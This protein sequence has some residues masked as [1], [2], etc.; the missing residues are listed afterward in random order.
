MRGRPRRIVWAGIPCD[1]QCSSE[2]I[3][4]DPGLRRG[5]G[6][7]ECG[8]FLLTPCPPHAVRTERSRSA[9]PTL[10]PGESRG[11]RLRSGLTEV[12]R[13]SHLRHAGSADTPA[14]SRALP[15]TPPPFTLSEVE[16]YALPFEPRA[17]L[18]CRLEFEKIAQTQKRPG[19]RSPGLFWLCRKDRPVRFPARSPPPVPE[20]R[21]R[22]PCRPCRPCRHRRAWRACLR[23]ARPRWL[24][25]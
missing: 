21:L 24:P 6:P 5:T 13:T 8:A 9:R 25:W 1:A 17:A 7:S 3:E 23:A 14:S 20:I 19:D 16:A 18:A 2:R 22:S 10:S 11:L 15:H 12:G 4:L